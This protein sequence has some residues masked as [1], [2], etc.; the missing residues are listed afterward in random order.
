VKESASGFSEQRR[1]PELRQMLDAIR[2]RMEQGEGP[3]AAR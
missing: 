2:E 1:A 3:T